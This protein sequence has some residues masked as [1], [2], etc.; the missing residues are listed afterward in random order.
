MLNRSASLAMSTSVPKA[1]TGKLDIK[2]HSPSI[3]YFLI[4]DQADLGPYCLQY[5]LPKYIM[6]INCCELG[7]KGGTFCRS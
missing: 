1:L 5:R 4:R 3:L 2:R 6:Q 7:E